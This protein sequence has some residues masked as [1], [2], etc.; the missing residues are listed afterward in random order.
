MKPYAGMIVSTMLLPILLCGCAAREYS[1]DSSMGVAVHENLAAQ[2]I[3][4]NGIPPTGP[5]GLYGVPSKAVIDRYDSSFMAPP[6]P[7]NAFSI[8]LGAAGTASMT[9]PATGTN[10]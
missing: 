10:P 1:M 7:A 3:Y 4:P 8:G 5:Q 2:I 6:P 9:G